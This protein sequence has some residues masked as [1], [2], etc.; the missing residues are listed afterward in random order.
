MW[1]LWFVMCYWHLWGFPGG[2]RGKD[3]S[4]QCRMHK[5]HGLNP[6]VRKIPWR[7]EWQP[8]LIFFPGE[9]PWTEELAVY[10]VHGVTKSWTWLKSLAHTY[11]WLDGR[12][13]GWTPGVG[14]GQGGL[15]CC[16][17]W[18]RK[19]SDM[20]EGLWTE[21]NRVKLK[22]PHQKDLEK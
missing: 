7:R 14:D 22:G 1:W 5:G 18:G 15:A 21:L 16:N 6:W 3:P 20:T 2:V 10:I 9:S 4:C 17:S 11:H 13:S 19:E 8:T 12:E